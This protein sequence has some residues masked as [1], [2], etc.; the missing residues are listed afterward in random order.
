VH[1]GIQELAQACPGLLRTPIQSLRKQKCAELRVFN[2]A[3]LRHGTQL[4]NGA[5]GVRLI[6][7]PAFEIFKV[8]GEQL[9]LRHERRY[10]RRS[11]STRQG[12]LRLTE[13]HC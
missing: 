10:P 1:L 4:A 7:G 13:A 9:R 8:F 2:R 5:L 6:T 3:A 11:L 12:Q